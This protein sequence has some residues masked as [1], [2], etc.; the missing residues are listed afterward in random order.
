MQSYAVGLLL[1]TIDFDIYTVTMI[2]LSKYSNDKM[3]WWMWPTSQNAE[4]KLWNDSES[5][6]VVDV[7][8]S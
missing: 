6:D 2:T 3:C 7:C 4:K 5:L 8:T 1:F